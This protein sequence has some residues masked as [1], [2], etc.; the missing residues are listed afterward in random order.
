M[1]KETFTMNKKELYRLEIIKKVVDKY[2]TQ[3]KAA[4]LL[5][6]TTRNV[7]KLK[8]KYQQ[9]GLQG[10]ISQKRGK[11]SNRKY[12]EAIKTQALHYVIQ[13][14]NLIY[15][16]KFASDLLEERANIFLSKETI[17]QW[18]ISEG[19][20]QP[21]LS[22][23]SKAHPPRDAREQFGELIQIDGSYHHWFGNEREKAC[24]IVFIDD[25]TS[26]IQLMRFFRTETTFAYFNVL[27]K[28][29]EL[30][31]LPLALYSDKH[32]VFRVNMVEPQNSTGF[33]QFGRAV[34]GLGIQ[35]IYAHSAQAKGKVERKNLDLQRRLIKEMEL[36]GIINM[37]EANDGYLDKFS[38][39]FNKR[40]Q[41]IAK[42]PLNAHIVVENL[43][44][45]DLHC[46]LQ[47][48]RVVSKNYTLS[49]KGQLLK[50]KKPNTVKKLCQ[51]QV[52][53]CEAESGEI[54]VLLNGQSLSY[55]VYNNKST[56]SEP[57]DK[58]AL[59]ISNVHLRS[60]H[61]PCADHPWR[62]YPKRSY[63][64]AGVK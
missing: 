2:I 53:V 49:Y 36:D 61:I 1:N 16:P 31:G 3:Q 41:K 62:H 33:T 17:R 43:E 54:T 7:R 9:L 32:S 64:A 60:V 18:L 19:V 21:K 6:C 38:K 28:Y 23:E 27:K 42:N 29:I 12:P 13:E 40:F 8:N 11:P 47:A 52:I 24:L 50:L 59:V 57:V 26:K 39:R 48:P 5:G 58:K 15:Q 20:Y 35:L 22:K 4:D 25:A 45:I 10:L 44:A 51:A 34:S 46:T 14:Y 63:S 30:Y 55:E 56:A 37:E